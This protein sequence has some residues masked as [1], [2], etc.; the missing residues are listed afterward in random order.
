MNATIKGKDLVITIPLVAPRPSKSGK[1]LVVATTGGNKETT[2]KVN[3]QPVVVGVN[4][5]IKL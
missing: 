2:A 1:T 5:Y 4:A 3:G